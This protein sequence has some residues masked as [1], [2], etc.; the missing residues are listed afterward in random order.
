MASLRLRGVSLASRAIVI[1]KAEVGTPAPSTPVQL[2]QEQTLQEH[3]QQLQSIQQQLR[4]MQQ[5]GQS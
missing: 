1:R 4:S 5:Q 2:V 3:Q